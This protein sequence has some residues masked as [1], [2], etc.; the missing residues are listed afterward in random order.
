MLRTILFIIC[1]CIAKVI[2]D[3]VTRRMIMP[4]PTYIVV[5]LLTGSVI[6]GIIVSPFIPKKDKIVKQTTVEEMR[7][8]EEPYSSDNN[9]EDGEVG[10]MGEYY[11]F[12]DSDKRYLTEEDV[13]EMDAS[14]VR[15]GLNE[16]YARHGRKFNDTELQNYFSS[17]A[18]YTP[19]YTPDEFSAIEG[20]VF[21]EYEKANVEFLA[22]LIK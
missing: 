12:P 7:E 4:L 6:G 21:N 10:S 14:Y 18:W 11:V 17:Q 9:V 13:H 8:N 15:L 1:L 19:E 22:N 16:I 2:V 3:K 5:V 20:S